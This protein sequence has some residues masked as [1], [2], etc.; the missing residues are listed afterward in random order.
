MGE[1]THCQKKKNAGQAPLKPKPLMQL[2]AVSNEQEHELW[3]HTHDKQ[4]RSLQLS[5]VHCAASRAHATHTHTSL[6]LHAPHF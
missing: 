5:P 3:C 1:F 4:T 6:T 2:P